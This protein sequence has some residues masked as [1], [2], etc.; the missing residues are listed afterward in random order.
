M[1]QPTSTPTTS[2]SSSTAP[3]KHQRLPAEASTDV[4]NV[5]QVNEDRFWVAPDSFDPRAIEKKGQLFV[6]ADGMGGYHAGDV[7]AD[8]V[9]KTMGESY[10]SKDADAT[11]DVMAALKF[12]VAQSQTK[13]N[14]EQQRNTDYAQMGSTVVAAVVRSDEVFVAN[15][16]DAR[17]YRLRNG[18]LKQ[19]SRDHSWVA[20]QVAAGVLKPSETKGHPLRS[21][22]TRAIGQP[23]ASPEPDITRFDWQHNDRLLLCS[24]GLWDMLTEEKLLQ[25]MEMP[26]AK[27]AAEALVNAA[28]AAGGV[29][30]ITVVVVGD[31]PEPPLLKK[32][33]APAM[34]PKLIG[35][36][37]GLIGALVIGLL[38][39]FSGVFDPEPEPV[40]TPEP[41]LP[42]ATVPRKPAAPPTAAPVVAVT[43][44][45]AA[46][47]QPTN[48]PAA[49]P[50]VQA[51]PTLL[52]AKPAPTRAATQSTIN[53]STNNAAANSA[54]ISDVKFCL[55]LSGNAC[56][57]NRT[58]YFTST[59]AVFVS[60]AP[61]LPE[62]TNFRVEWQRNGE[63]WGKPDICSVTAG[64]CEPASPDVSPSWD[65]VYLPA[66]VGARR[67]TYAFKLIVGEAVVAQGQFTVK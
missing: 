9:A 67:G 31:L 12:A 4:G 3:K 26:K 19:L 32:L 46:P 61:A 39:A 17:C 55:Q 62:G 65:R 57:A 66:N 54:T 8:I 51:T 30:N 45:S 36:V 37:G 60:Y 10:Y 5:R 22:I 41:P 7:A 35:I 50:V 42:T 16:G 20:E 1:T 40:P 48:T 47:A 34:L 49:A 15:V 2:A 59:Q 33:M 28:N 64:K 44:P 43:A 21:A 29:D 27:D 25:L 18:Q 58:S 52:G 63:V 24:D 6:V 56:A 11:K 13:V 14:E 53:Q 38:V 23:Q